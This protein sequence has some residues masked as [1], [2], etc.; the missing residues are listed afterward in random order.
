MTAWIFL[1]LAITL[2]VAGTFLLKP[3]RP[4]SNSL[5]AALRRALKSR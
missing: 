1:A 4:C 5:S 3:L 2:E